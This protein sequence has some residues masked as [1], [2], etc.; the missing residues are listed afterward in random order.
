M[1]EAQSPA[2]D[3]AED[4]GNAAEHMESAQ[5]SLENTEPAA[6]QPQQTVR[7]S[8]TPIKLRFEPQYSIIRPDRLGTSWNIRFQ[9]A[10]VNSNPFG[11]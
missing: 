10:P 4:L 2:P 11:S 5:G 6:A 7:W 8:N 1:I 9:V 3:A